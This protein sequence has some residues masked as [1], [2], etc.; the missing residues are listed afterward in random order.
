LEDRK[1]FSLWVQKHLKPFAVKSSRKTPLTLDEAKFLSE[2]HLPSCGRVWPHVDT[3]CH[4][5]RTRVCYFWLLCSELQQKMQMHT[6][7]S[8][9]LK[10]TNEFT[11]SWQRN[12]FTLIWEIHRHTQAIPKECLGF[13]SQWNCYHISGEW[14]VSGTPQTVEKHETLRKDIHF[15]KGS[16]R[17]NTEH[18][19]FMELKT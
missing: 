6:L 1:A 19:S 5:V 12:Y 15:C 14:K 8:K 13:S 3:K 11:S 16:L 4:T 18:F 9:T 10:V 2:L 7:A 17:D